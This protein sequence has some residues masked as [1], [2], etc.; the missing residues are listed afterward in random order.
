VG[1]APATSSLP[2][3]PPPAVSTVTVTEAATVTEAPAV[4]EAPVM[5]DAAVT[6]PAPIVEA[7]RDA[8]VAAPAEGTDAPAAAAD[9]RPAPTP[10]RRPVVAAVRRALRAVA[11]AVIGAVLWLLLLTTAPRLA[12]WEPTIITGRSMEPAIERGDLVVVRPAPAS[13]YVEGAVITFADAD[14]PDRLVTHRIVAV[15]PDGALVTKGDN[16]RDSDPQPVTLD[17]VRGRAVLRVPWAG[18][19]VVWYL[20]GRWGPLAALAVGIVAAL[21]T[22]FA[23]PRRSR[24]ARRRR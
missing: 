2:G 10:V 4:T 9:P 11:F 3:E 21:R 19:P 1:P 6:V 5:R 13:A 22:A 8:G 15:R 12:G 18:R 7:P 14:R 23:R 16:N 24:P 17:R 20:D